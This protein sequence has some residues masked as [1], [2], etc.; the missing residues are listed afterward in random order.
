MVNIN[1]P[2]SDAGYL[3]N[4]NTLEIPYNRVWAINRRSIADE[5]NDM[6][7]FL[8]TLTDGYDP[9]NPDCA[10]AARAMP[11]PQPRP[12]VQLEDRQPMNA[13]RN[14]LA[15]LLSCA[16]ACTPIARAADPAPVN[17]DL[18]QQA[19]AAAR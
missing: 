17:A 9:N 1:V 8:C 3:G 14:H 12:P 5:I 13:T 10:G 19:R 16:A 15:A 6:I 7:T 4:V 2:G 18:V 11:V